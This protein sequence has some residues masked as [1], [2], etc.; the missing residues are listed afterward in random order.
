MQAGRAD[1]IAVVPLK[2]LTDNIED[3][4]VDLKTLL[5]ENQIA[6]RPIHYVLSSNTSLAYPM[7]QGQVR[8][9]P[10]ACMLRYAVNVGSFYAVSLS[11]QWTL[12]V[13]F[14]PVARVWS[15]RRGHADVDSQVS[16]GSVRQSPRH[17]QRGRTHGCRWVR[18]VHRLTRGA[19][20]LVRLYDVTG[21]LC[22]HHRVVKR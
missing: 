10:I 22:R 3:F 21:S 13:L 5:D 7:C 1:S 20:V 11:L 9:A 8:S 16:R 18:H 17:H 6:Q 14:C 12:H 19:F 15:G 2:P 4:L